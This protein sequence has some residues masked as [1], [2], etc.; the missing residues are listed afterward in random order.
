M[1]FLAGTSAAQNC[2]GTE[3][4]GPKDGTDSQAKNID[5]TKITDEH[6]T[7]LVTI[8]QPQLPDGNTTRIV[9]DETHVYRVQAPFDKVETRIGQRLPSGA[10]G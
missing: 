2:G 9:P 7:D 5:L 1:L 3:R 6:V 10:H 8:S 4:W